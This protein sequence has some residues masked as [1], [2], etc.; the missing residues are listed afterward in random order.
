MNGEPG[1]AAEGD[2]IYRST[3]YPPDRSILF[4]NEASHTPHWPMRQFFYCVQRSPHGGDTPHRGLPP[5]LRCAGP[6]GP[7]RVRAAPAALRAQ[8]LT[9]SL[10]ELLRKSL[11]HEEVAFAEPVAFEVLD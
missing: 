10:A 1:Q 3:P 8:A 9:G 7:G 11:V 6:G 4:H 2:F 5:P